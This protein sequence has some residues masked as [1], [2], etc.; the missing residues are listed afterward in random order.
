MFER[1]ENVLKACQEKNITI[2]LKKLQIGKTTT[3]AG[4]NICPGYQTPT[5][6]LVEAI[7]N[8][9]VPYTLK[10]LRGF[11]GLANQLA[12]FIPDGDHITEPLRALIK[13]K[14]V[15]SWEEE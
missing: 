5:Q 10:A 13:V 3:F 14:S 11:L 6:N 7:K 2:S 1:A 9:E 4:F 12:H 8:F 15:F